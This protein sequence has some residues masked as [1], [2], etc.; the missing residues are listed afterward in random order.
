MK[1][2]KISLGVLLGVFLGAL[3]AQSVLIIL[4]K[5]E[6]YSPSTHIFRI[7]VVVICGAYIGGFVQ[8]R[9]N[10]E[11]V[12]SNSPLKILKVV[13][14]FFLGFFLASVFSSALI[15]QS[16]ISRTTDI[17]RLIVSVC[18]GITGAVITYKRVNLKKYED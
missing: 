9:V 6:I 10:D 16:E 3:V 4:G 7:T 5:G 14:G 17:I 12:T 15:S 8:K 13:G 11:S 2:L 1:I 18:G